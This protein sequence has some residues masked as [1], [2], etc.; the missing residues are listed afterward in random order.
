MK[1]KNLLSAVLAAALTMSSL[2]G[3][4]GSQEKTMGSA[5]QTTATTT[6][7]ESPGGQEMD[8]IDPTQ[9]KEKIVFWGAWAEDTGPAD[10]IAEFN[11]KFPNIEVEYV[12]FTN[13]D[14]GNVKMDT[15]LLAGIDVDVFLNFGT[16]RL[17]PRAEKGLV[18]N[19]DDLLVRDGFD[20]TKEYGANA[21]NIDGSYYGLPI[22]TLSDFVILNKTALDEAG[23]SVPVEWDL[24]TYKD[25]ALK[26]TSGEGGNK[27]YGTCDWNFILNWAMPA[28]SKLEDNPWYNEAGLSN[29]DNEAYKTALNFKTNMEN[30]LQ[31]QYPYKQLTAQKISPYDVF[32]RDECKMAIATS[33]ATRFLK[34]METYPRNFVTSFAPYPVIDIA[35]NTGGT[36]GTYFFSYISMGAK[37]EGTK[38]EAAWQFMKWLGTEGNTMFASVGHIPAWKDADKDQIVEI[39]LGT[40]MAEY[41]DI[42]TF[43]RVVLNTDER[44]IGQDITNLTAYNQLTTI[45][46]EEAELAVYGE[47]TVD[48]ALQDMKKRSDTEIVK[49]K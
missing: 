7:Q 14:E 24:E 30:E 21:H 18:S 20:V 2:S 22:G 35:N 33:G 28:Y 25:Y 40:D 9:L 44:A 42:D 31:I 41:V 4:S 8:T 34:D 1:K 15:S 29:W 19:I 47:K 43:K 3:C 26:L 6:G 36:G 39:M 32:F 38:R 12:K 37:L 49:V 11:K 23:L 17:H 13:T 10:W 27:V 16:K 45:M 48:Q 46:K 5:M